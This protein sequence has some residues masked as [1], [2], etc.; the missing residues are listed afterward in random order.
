MIRYRLDESIPA[1]G[2]LTPREAAK[3]PEGRQRLLSRFDYIAREQGRRKMRPGMLAPDYG[4]AKKLL[5]LE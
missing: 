5:E 1:L 4:K 3:T 2:R